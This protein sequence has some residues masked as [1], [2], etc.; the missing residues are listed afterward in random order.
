MMGPYN[1]VTHDLRGLLAIETL[2]VSYCV[3]KLDCDKL[4]LTY[5][6]IDK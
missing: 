3:D 1:D 2:H 4:P 5:Q 6:K